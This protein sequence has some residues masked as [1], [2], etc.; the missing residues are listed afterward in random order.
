MSH[1][2]G[3]IFDAIVRIDK[4]P[5]GGRS[6]VVEANDVERAAIAAAMNI[7]SV[8]S[9]VSRLAVTPFRGGLRALGSLDAVVSQA[10]V[11]SFEPVSE[12]IS[13]PIDR[14]FL[15]APRDG[16]SPAPGSETFIDLED[17]DFPDHIDGAE[18]DLSALMLETLA[19]A[20]DPYPKREGETLETID[21]KLDAPA[22][23][24]F[25]KLA[26]LNKTRDS[27]D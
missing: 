16:N 23:G 19:L 6:V 26:A 15:P 4:L 7:L 13:E 21:A 14:V 18:V 27:D 3:P 24:P 25:A 12:A 11:V 22:E 5:T 2:P 17:E 8:E 1:S 20:L 9:F 10:S